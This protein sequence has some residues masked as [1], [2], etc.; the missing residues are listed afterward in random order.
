MG[1]LPCLSVTGG[2]YGW[3]HLKYHYSDRFST[4][5]VIRDESSD[6]HCV[7]VSSLSRVKGSVAT[8]MLG[9]RHCDV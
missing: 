3:P 4:H 1:G 2:V 7:V 5:S 9:P 8:Q 6:F